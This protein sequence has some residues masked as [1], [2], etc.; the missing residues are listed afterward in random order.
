MAQHFDI[1][2][3]QTG[4]YITFLSAAVMV[5]KALNYD[6]LVVECIGGFTIVVSKDSRVTDLAKIYE[7]EKKLLEKKKA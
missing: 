1:R 2:I 4:D 5:C 6:M 7:L 3:I